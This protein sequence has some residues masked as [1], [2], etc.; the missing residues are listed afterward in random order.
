M[1]YSV[2][3]TLRYGN[4]VRTIDLN[5]VEFTPTVGIPDYL[6]HNLDF[7]GVQLLYSPKHG[8]L[9]A[10]QHYKLVGNL[11]VIPCP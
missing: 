11:E 1:R 6:Y 5:C 9:W 3:C 8:D 4:D 10:T 2:K 7:G